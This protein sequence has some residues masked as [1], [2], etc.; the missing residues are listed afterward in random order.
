VAKDKAAE[1]MTLA[2]AAARYLGM[3]IDKGSMSE[4]ATADAQ[5]AVARF[6]QWFGQEKK[7]STLTTV[8]VERFVEESAG[9]GGSQGRNIEPVRPFLA[10]L[11][12]AGLTESNL[13]TAV[14]IRRSES[15][16]SALLAA[17]SVQMTQS[18]FDSMKRE[19][20]ELIGKRPMIAEA[21]HLAMADKDF[22]ENAPLDAARDQQAHIEAQIRRIEQLLKKAVVVDSSSGVAGTVRVGCFVKVMNL[23]SSQEFRYQLVSPNEVNPRE[24]KISIASPVGKALL[25]HAAEDEVSVAVPSGTVRLKVVAVED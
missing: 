20:E 1:Q 16:S 5:A 11:K 9:R 14:K 23:D 24:G 17:D 10:Y 2:E 3:L 4:R 21:L 22:R 19:L 6:T 18:G 15:E 25:E 8:D 12:K 13:S 7:L